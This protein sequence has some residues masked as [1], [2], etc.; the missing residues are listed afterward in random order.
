MIFWLLSY[1]DLDTADDSVFVHHCYNLRYLIH[2]LATVHNIQGVNPG[3]FLS[4]VIFC[5]FLDLIKWAML[6]LMLSR[7]SVLLNNKMGEALQ[8]TYNRRSFKQLNFQQSI[9][10]LFRLLKP[11]VQA[12]LIEHIIEKLMSVV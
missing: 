12:E 3:S 5:S 6:K 8:V 7:T 1:R 11:T 10:V 2:A 4:K 9:L